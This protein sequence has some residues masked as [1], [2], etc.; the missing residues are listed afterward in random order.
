MKLLFAVLS[1]LVNGFDLHSQELA[2]LNAE[3]KIFFNAKI[4]TADE[5][6]LY[7]E[8]I[9]IRGT[10]IIA[11]GNLQEVKTA[12]SKDAEMIDMGGR[13]L[14]PGFVD[15]HNHAIE[16]GKEL[17]SP[18]VSDSM[19]SAHDLALFA[20][21]IRKS[22]NGMRG[23][24]IVINGLNITT[25]SHL[26]ELEKVFDAGAFIEQP[27]MLFGSDG[28]TGWGNKSMMR[29]AGI[30]KNFLKNLT[31]AERKYFGISKDGNSNGFIAD[32]GLDKIYR[33][34]PE[35]TSS[36][37]AGAEKAMEYNNQFGITALLDPAAGDISEGLGNSILKSY[38]YLSVNHKLSAHVAAVVTANADADPL[39]QIESLKSIQMRFNSIPN[40]EVIGFKIFADGVIEYP[41]QTAAISKP[42]LN[43]GSMGALMFVPENFSLFATA[44]D[45]ANLLVHVHAIGIVR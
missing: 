32:S 17:V 25:W 37:R 20:L 22:G 6:Q 35:D 2:V 34:L 42:Y 11:V 36:W 30:T 38:E 19:R 39:P 23:K 3:E 8:A 44:A 21:E 12:V 13:C 16:G 9:A 28:H 10:K 15:S 45:K 40:L 5:Q 18:H 26:E 27:V 29:D 31:T 7:A 1:L 24:Y 14:L 33:I 4:F 43:T 41:S